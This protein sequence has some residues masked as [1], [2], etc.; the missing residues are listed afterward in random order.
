M[1]VDLAEARDQG[2]TIERPER[3]YGF[4]SHGCLVK[5]AKSPQSYVAKVEAWLGAQ[6]RSEHSSE[7]E[8]LRVGETPVIDEGIRQWYRS[9]RCCLSDA[10][11]EVVK[12][13]DEEQ[14]TAPTN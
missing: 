2:L 6:A 7:H 4:C 9:C 11:P 3:E 8:H 14:E 1:V 5:F 12:M 13:L 10:Y